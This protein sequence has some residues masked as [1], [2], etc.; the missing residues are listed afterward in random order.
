MAVA[1]GVVG[2]ALR[3]YIDRVLPMPAR[4]RRAE[5]RVERALADHRIWLERN[6]KEMR[7]ELESVREAHAGR[8]TFDSSI[9]LADE[10]RVRERYVNA[11]RDHQR[12]M[13]RESEDALVELGPLERL[14]LR[15]K[16]RKNGPDQ[17]SLEEQ[18]FRD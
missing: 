11:L 7:R 16:L 12:A 15:F 5:L 4:T 6:E 8:G 17:P 13:I 14:R 2:A 9:R 18:L 1:G 3:P 10:Q